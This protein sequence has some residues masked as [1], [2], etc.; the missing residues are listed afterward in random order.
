M[1]VKIN[2]FCMSI[3]FLQSP[4]RSKLSNTTFIHRPTVV[5][6]TWKSKI[7]FWLNLRLWNWKSMHVAW[8]SV[9]PKNSWSDFFIEQPVDKPFNTGVQ[10]GIYEGRGVFL[11][12]GHC[13][14]HFNY[15]AR[16]KGP[17]GKNFG[18]LLLEK[19]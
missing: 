3:I 5:V 18:Y 8:S 19:L 10:P 2:V 1:I 11:E 14:K 7:P 16:K 17:A 13:D 4:L 9:V 6:V 15:D 12:L